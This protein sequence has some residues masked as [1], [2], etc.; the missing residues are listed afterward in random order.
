MNERRWRMIRTYTIS[1]N[2]SVRSTST[3]LLVYVK[4][5]SSSRSWPVSFI[6]SP[7]CMTSSIVRTYILTIT[8][9]LASTVLQW[10]V[11]PLPWCVFV[12]G[13]QNCDD[14][15][16]LDRERGGDFFLRWWQLGIKL[17]SL[18]SFLFFP[19]FSSGKDFSLSICHFLFA[20][21]HTSKKR[22]EDI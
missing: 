22:C 9:L 3:Y 18:S 2:S 7:H 10:F 4:T 20:G 8:V 21:C 12:E 6:F 17:S 19:L 14:A 11:F 13:K 5:W 15:I 16:C 1:N